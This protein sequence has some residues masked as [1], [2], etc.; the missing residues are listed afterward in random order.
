MICVSI[1]EKTAQ[2]CI[3]ALKGVF[4]A[5][6]RLDKVSLKKGDVKRIFSLKKKLI[7]T[8]RKTSYGDEKRLNALLEA[9][10]CGAE[11]VDIDIKEN[12]EFRKKIVAAARKRHCKI[13]ISFHD[14]KKTPSRHALEKIVS[15]CFALKADI[16]KV[17][18]KVN[19]S[20]DNAL[21]LGLLAL[22][23]KMIVVGMG[24]KGKITR[25]AR[26]LLG[27]RFSF[28][29]SSKGK[30]TAIGQISEKNLKKIFGAIK[31]A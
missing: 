14:F 16:A 15:K 21:L 13:I 24:N 7:A 9:I 17:A 8:F 23:K 20:K 12:E 4:F 31:N 18:C 1:G 26:P 19:S 6:I 11:F 5:E 3:K 22:D 10:N 27:S 25:I 30:E 2:K 29:A 28:A